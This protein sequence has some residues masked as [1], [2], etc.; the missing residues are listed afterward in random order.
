MKT[1]L[2]E[3]ENAKMIVLFHWPS[4]IEV[5]YVVWTENMMVRFQLAFRL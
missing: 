2:L 5:M 4:I 3:N 1:E